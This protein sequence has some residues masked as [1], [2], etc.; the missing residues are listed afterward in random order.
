[1]SKVGKF[2]IAIPLRSEIFY[3]NEGN[4][5]YTRDNIV[6]LISTCKSNW[7]FKYDHSN[8][9]ICFL[10]VVPVFSFFFFNFQV[11]LFE[12]FFWQNVC[13]QKNYRVI[14]HSNVLFLN[15][16][17]YFLSTPILPLSIPQ[18][19]FLTHYSFFEFLKYL[20]FFVADF[21]SFHYAYVFSI[22]AK[23]DCGF[24]WSISHEVITRYK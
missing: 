2:E 18:I 14:N 13:V 9:K 20:F 23:T 8:R 10:E 15:A 5:R 7:T 22:Y 19:L 12:F 4:E 24:I 21:S 11:S 3:I 16:K 17:I 1:M 6:K